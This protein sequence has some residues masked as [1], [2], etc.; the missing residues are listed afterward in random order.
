MKKL[1]NNFSNASILDQIKHRLNYEIIVDLYEYI[2]DEE[3]KILKLCFAKCKDRT[4]HR[5]SL[6]QKCIEK[7]IKEKKEFKKKCYRCYKSDEL[8]EYKEDNEFLQLNLCF[9][10]CGVKLEHKH[11]LC[12]KCINKIELEKNELR[13]NFNGS[14]NNR[15]IVIGYMRN[16]GFYSF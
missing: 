15:D 10:K 13:N 12:Q 1:Q 5:H 9:A 7:I 16:K 11:L 6:C 8:I 4:S 3:F 2:E 14:L